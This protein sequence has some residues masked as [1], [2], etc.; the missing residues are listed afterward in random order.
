MK[1]M[2]I[3]LALGAA[4]SVAQAEP[5]RGTY[6][7]TDPSRIGA[8][9]AAP[10]DVSHIIYMDRCAGGCTLTPGSDGTHNQSEIIDNQVHMSAY[11]GSDANW[12]ALVQC[13][14]MTYAP[15]AVTIT[16]QRPPNGTAYHHAIVA[17][18][19]AEAGQPSN[20]LGVSPFACGYLPNA[21]SFTFANE[22]P[23]SIYDLCWTVSQ[24][25]SH[26]WGL[27]HKFDDRDPMT[28]LSSG[29]AMKTFQNQA[30]RCGEY[31]ARDC[32][33]DYAGTGNTQ[34]N[35]YALILATFGPNMPDTT[36]PSVHITAPASGASVMP[37]FSVTADVTDN[38][39]V[40]KAEL[41]I[42]GN[43]IGTTS[44]APF[45]WNAPSSLTQGSHHVEVKAYD[46]ANNTATDAVDVAYGM[47]CTM[48]SQC[49]TSGD[50]C[51]G[52]HC[53]PGPDQQG[54]LGSECTGNE[55]CTSGDCATDGTHKYCVE[56]CDPSK[57]QCPNGFSCQSSGAAGVCWPGADNGGGGGCE[58]GGGSDAP[59]ILFL[60][61]A[62]V[63]ITRRRR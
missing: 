48:N 41:R 2:L 15:F 42:D 28:Y 51:L 10:S 53:V 55:M 32:G 33:C 46:L 58:S 25:T 56:P 62:G 17:G 23:T 22:E 4:S 12:Q 34:E 13:V 6:R 30:G 40:A 16:D 47:V 19:S 54:G 50:L 20:V 44:T 37:G 57:H 45:A 26:S 63:L 24:E 31:S 7:F 35:S 27:D 36:P 21:I 9:W 61:L 38:V 60:G 29:P 43:L 14:Q 5:A 1:G 59:L 39:A 49:T 8:K 11:A 18:S 52:G 3:V